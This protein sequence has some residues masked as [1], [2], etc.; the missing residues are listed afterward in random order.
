LKVLNLFIE[1]GDFYFML[2]WEYNLYILWKNVTCFLN[3]ED[4]C[5]LFLFGFGNA[6]LLKLWELSWIEIGLFIHVFHHLTHSIV[7]G[8]TNTWSR[9]YCPPLYGMLFV[10]YSTNDILTL[11]CNLLRSTSVVL[12]VLVEVSC[13]YD[14]GGLFLPLSCDIDQLYFVRSIQESK[15]LDCCWNYAVDWSGYTDCH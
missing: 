6:V 1:V 12:F 13:I 5:R 3:L 14:V 2:Y 9:R 10:S 11:I 8:V 4:K 15:S 7:P